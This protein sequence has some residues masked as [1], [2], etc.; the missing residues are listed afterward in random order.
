MNP[1]GSIPMDVKSAL[2]SLSVKT[3]EICYYAKKAHNVNYSN[4]YIQAK[5][6]SYPER[7]DLKVERIIAEFLCVLYYIWDT[8]GIRYTRNYLKDTIDSF[9]EP[10]EKLTTY[11]SQNIQKVY[12]DLWLS[13]LPGDPLP[14][15]KPAKPKNKGKTKNS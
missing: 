4:V 13:P 15:D 12:E 7:R 5:I 14:G 3:T 2:N 11:I 9:P 8:Y 1:S 6:D 10:D